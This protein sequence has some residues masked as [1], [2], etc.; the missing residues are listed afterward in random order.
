[1]G[2]AP[3]HLTVGGHDHVLEEGEVLVFR[4]DQQHTYMNTGDAEVVG[5]SVVTLAPV[6]D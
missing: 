3:D 5:V 2:S 4:G 1:M 6:P